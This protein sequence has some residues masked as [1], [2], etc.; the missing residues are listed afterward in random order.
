MGSTEKNSK[1]PD[2]RVLRAFSLRQ[3]QPDA[4]AKVQSHLQ[5]CPPCAL[6]QGDIAA[7]LASQSTA[8]K[9]EPNDAA[10]A[11]PAELVDHPTYRIVHKIARGGMGVLYLVEH[12]LTSRHEA[13][14]VIHPELANRPD[15]RARFM[16]EIQAA[17]KLDHPNIV[18]TLTAIQ[19]GSLLAMVMDY[20]PGM[21]LKK[22]V[23]QLGKLNLHEALDFTCQIALGLEHAHEKRIVHRDIKPS[24]LM[25]TNTGKTKLVRILDFGL[26][27]SADEKN[28]SMEPATEEGLL[29]TYDFMAPEQA[30]NASKADIRSDLYSLGCTLYYML[31]GKVPFPDLS[32]TAALR[33]HRSQAFPRLNETR[34]D[35]PTEA[36]TLLDRLVA[37]NPSQRFAN[38]TELLVAL[39]KL[40]AQLDK[41]DE[42]NTPVTTIPSNIVIPA[43]ARSPSP[44]VASL[45]LP[46][47]SFLKTSLS[48]R[49]E[50]R[51]KRIL[52]PGWLESSHGCSPL[53]RSDQ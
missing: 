38:P 46:E 30:L 37:K 31:T 26:V 14:K 17:A 5:R 35:I 28:S 4:M 2:D 47:M 19:E 9:R 13:L 16:R 24:N 12:R 39:G 36:Q 22:L 18:R 27:R 45:F 7:E 10:D 42:P 51:R 20:A 11:V 40:Q 41:S 32:R 8:T 3:L 21:T 33:A 15:V 34:N 49:Y 53:L 50:K 1:H 29:G 23:A 43:T 48:S 44:V 25:V 52:G 6:R